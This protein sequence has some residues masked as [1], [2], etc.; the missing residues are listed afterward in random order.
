MTIGGI[1]LYVLFYIGMLNIADRY[2]RSKLGWFFLGLMISPLFSMLLISFCGP[3]KHLRR[4]CY[5]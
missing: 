5:E 4:Q 1:I 3:A 2:G